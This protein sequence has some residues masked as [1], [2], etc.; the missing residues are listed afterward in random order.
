LFFSGVDPALDL[1]TVPFASLTGTGTAVTT[2]SVTT[3]DTAALAWNVNTIDG[4]SATHTPPTGFTE[5]GDVTPWS[6]AYGIASGDGSQSAAGAT[7]G[8]SSV[9]A[10]GLVAL[11]PVISVGTPLVSITHV[12]SA[13]VRRASTF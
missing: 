13:A 11:A 7:N 2:L 10:A 12:S 3:V 9:W 8:T 6:S 1:A 5:V 4:G